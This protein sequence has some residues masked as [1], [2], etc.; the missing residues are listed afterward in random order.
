ME[1]KGE[2]GIVRVGGGPADG[3]GGDLVEKLR[4][5]TV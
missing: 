2:Q 1:E 4:R 3:G 5:V